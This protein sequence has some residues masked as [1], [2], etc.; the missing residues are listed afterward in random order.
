MRPRLA[1]TILAASLTL[2]HL[3]Y[4]ASAEECDAKCLAK[5]AQDPL[6]D[7]RAIMIF[8]MLFQELFHILFCVV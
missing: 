3:S 4:P 5:K 1:I 6:G 7:V 8:L 2:I